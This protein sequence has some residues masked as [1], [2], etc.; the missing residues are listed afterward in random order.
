MR[1]YFGV[2]SIKS[3]NTYRTNVPHAIKISDGNIWSKRPR[4][5]DFVNNLTNIAWNS[6]PEELA[7]VG[8]FPDSIVSHSTQEHC[9]TLYLSLSVSRP[10]R[11][12]PLDC[13]DC[14]VRDWLCCLGLIVLS[15]TRGH[16]R[17]VKWPTDGVF[18]ST[19]YVTE[20]I[21]Q[22]DTLMPVGPRGLWNG[23]NRTLSKGLSG[24]K[25]T[26]AASRPRMS[27]IRLCEC[28]YTE[29]TAS[30]SSEFPSGSRPNLKWK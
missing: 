24:N 17:Y 8:I 6:R 1:F 16:T 19:R 14:V 4:G 15:G 13:V 12:P 26:S 20:H 9:H 25:T 18:D 10:Q 23:S 2:R 11:A 30:S 22:N 5:F 28:V 29:F 21:L 7:E 3:K 27:E